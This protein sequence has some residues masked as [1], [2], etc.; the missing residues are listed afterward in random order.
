MCLRLWAKQIEHWK[1]SP[2]GTAYMLEREIDESARL[3]AQ[4][5]TL[6]P[7]RS[8]IVAHVHLLVNHPTSRTRLPSPPQSAPRSTN[9]L[10]TPCPGR[11]RSAHVWPCRRCRYQS[12]PAPEVLIIL[13]L[14]DHADTRA[15][16]VREMVCP[17]RD[18]RHGLDRYL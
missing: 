7:V 6:P 18:K 16:L 10:L 8:L 3:H 11:R 17:H 9:R 4:H 14:S 12:L 1:W 15:V 5:L 13:N 2:S